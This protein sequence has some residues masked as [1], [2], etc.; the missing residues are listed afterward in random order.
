MRDG[1]LCTNSRQESIPC[2]HRL[3]CQRH[4]PAI[5]AATAVPRLV[6]LELLGSQ[7]PHAQ[8]Q[9]APPPEIH[10]MVSHAMTPTAVAHL[11]VPAE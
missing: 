10:A 7:T 1:T 6:C 11:E 8:S 4:G 9:K 2:R 5:A 3:C